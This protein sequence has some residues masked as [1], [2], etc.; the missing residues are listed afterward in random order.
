VFNVQG[1]KVQ[2]A[3]FKIQNYVPKLFK[4]KKITTKALKPRNKADQIWSFY[5][6]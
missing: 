1:I 3:R 6:F 2:R 4:K 5:I